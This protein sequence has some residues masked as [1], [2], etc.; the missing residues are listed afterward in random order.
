MEDINYNEIFGLAEDDAGVEEQDVADPAE[1]QNETEGEEEQDVADPAGEDDE[2]TG[3]EDSEDGDEEP[4]KSGKKSQ[5]AE[6]NAS[7][8]AA[9]RKAER[10]KEAALQAEKEKFNSLIAEAGFVN[11]FDNTPVKTMEQLEQYAE[12]ARTERLNSIRSK[13]GMSEEEFS[14]MVNGLP[15]VREAKALA[16]QA[17]EERMQ[18]QMEQHIAEISKLNPNIRTMEDLGKDP[19]FPEIREKVRQHKIP[20]S[21]AYRLV[22]HDEIV[23]K[24]TERAQASAHRAAAGK[25]HMKKTADPRGKTDSVVPADVAE[26]YR[27]F[28]PSLTDEEIRKDYNNRRRNKNV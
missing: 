27:I 14:E 24:A 15:E 7:F 9:R 8:A 1:D 20:V 13:S 26:M 16:A 5:S 3:N 19:K 28:D 6:E 22:Y 2:P 4:V 17:M 21:D 12:L 23:Q 25:S 10:E 11:P 18:R